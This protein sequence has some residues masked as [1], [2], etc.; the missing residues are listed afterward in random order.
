MM[1]IQPK[2]ATSTVFGAAESSGPRF[3]VDCC[4]ALVPSLSRQ[5]IVFENAKN[6]CAV[7]TA[8]LVQAA[9]DGTTVEEWSPP[10]SLALCPKGPT[11]IKDRT[12]QHFNAM[13]SPLVGFSVKMALWYQ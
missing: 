6:G 13:I 7:C 8:G 10:S 11:L 5:I 3:L 9:V 1:R 4:L 2:L 12:S